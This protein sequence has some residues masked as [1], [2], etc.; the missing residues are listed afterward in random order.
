MCMSR[1]FTY[2][3]RM[4]YLTMMER[5][6]NELARLFGCRNLEN[7]TTEPILSNNNI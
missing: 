6:V 7:G 2:I 4:P 3:K 5:E 1:E